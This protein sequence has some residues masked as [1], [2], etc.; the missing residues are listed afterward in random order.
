[1]TPDIQPRIF[2]G[3]ID[4]EKA[5]VLFDVIIL[6]DNGMFPDII[7]QLTSQLCDTFAD[8]KPSAQ[9]IKTIGNLKYS[10]YGIC[11]DNM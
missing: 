3:N 8:V 11:C 1:M 5:T 4:K 6:L 7:E 2:E 10:N 9:G